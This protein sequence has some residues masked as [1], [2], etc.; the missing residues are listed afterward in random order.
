MAEYAAQYADLKDRPVKE[1][2]CLFDVDGTLTPARKRVS[3]EMLKL[4]SELRHKCAIG[5]V[6]HDHVL[7]ILSR[8]KPRPDL[9]LVFR[10]SGHYFRLRLVQ[11]WAAYLVSATVFRD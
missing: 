8:P 7:L 6:R 5:F 9:S 4:L 1:T 3:S 2:I 10:I 11:V